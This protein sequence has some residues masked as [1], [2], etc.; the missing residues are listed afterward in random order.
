MSASGT[1]PA[2]ITRRATS[3]ACA[4]GQRLGR[5]AGHVGIDITLRI[6]HI[7]KDDQAG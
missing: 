1:R 5:I 2:S 4:I 3:G 7:G 6:G